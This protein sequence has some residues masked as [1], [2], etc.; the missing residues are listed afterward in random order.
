MFYVLKKKIKKITEGLEK[1][2]NESKLK[3][4]LF[5]VDSIIM[6]KGKK[7]RKKK[8]ERRKKRKKKEGKEGMEGG[9]KERKRKRKN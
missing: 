8:E 6:V 4:I 9:R 2:Q 5:H 3:Q 7:E 1:L